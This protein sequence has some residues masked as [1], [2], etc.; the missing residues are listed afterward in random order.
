MELKIQKLDNMWDQ[1][2][3]ILSTSYFIFDKVDEADDFAQLRAVYKW[4]FNNSDSA[5]FVWL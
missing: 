2:K 4:L 5:N 3:I 1:Y